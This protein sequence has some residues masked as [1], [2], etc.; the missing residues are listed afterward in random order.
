MFDAVGFDYDGV[1]ADSRAVAFNAATEIANLFGRQDQITSMFQY[2]AVF[3]Q[4]ERLCE[5]DVSSEEAL[6]ALHRLMMRTRTAQVPLFEPVLALAG[7]LSTEK[8]IITSTLRGTV[9]RRLAGNEYI[10]KTVL[11]HEDGLKEE[12]LAQWSA[13]KRCVYI[14]D[15]VRDIHHCRGCAVKV[16]AVTWGFDTPEDLARAA[17]DWS[18][19][20]VSE[21][22]KILTNIIK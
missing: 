4:L 3:T 17:P 14:T 13:G 2:R 20:N 9:L 18:V 19:N 21:L 22:Q 8:V 6:R 10:F 11:G 5:G 12:N 7:R 16:I 15:N 1:I